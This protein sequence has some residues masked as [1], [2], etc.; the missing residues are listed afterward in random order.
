MIIPFSG[1][2]CDSKLR[3]FIIKIQN[4]AVGEETV[5]ADGS[6]GANPVRLLLEPNIATDLHRQTQV[7][8]KV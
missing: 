4:N 3:D 1:P 8:Q 7:V 6:F 2:T 5:M